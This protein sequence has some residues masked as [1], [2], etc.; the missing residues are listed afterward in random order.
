MNCEALNRRACNN[1]A[2]NGFESCSSATVVDVILGGIP[3]LGFLKA[4]IVGFG[5]V[6]LLHSS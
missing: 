2:G 6:F 3:R 5:F 1:G 4:I